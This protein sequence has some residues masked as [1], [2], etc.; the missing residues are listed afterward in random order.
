VDGLTLVLALAVAFVVGVAAGLLLAH[1]G[2]MASRLDPRLESLSAS[3]DRRLA[4]LD[5]R[6]GHSLETVQT[7][8]LEAVAVAADVRERIA[9]VSGVAQQVLEHAREL[10]R[11]EDLLRPP[12]A[13]GAF[14]EML[15]EQVLNQGLP[16]GT[17]RTQHSFR[18]GARV[19]A[20]LV[21]GERLVPVDAKFPLDAFTRMSALDEG[22]SDRQKHRRA[23]VR[24]ARG[25][26]DAI[27]DKYVRPDEGTYEF[28]LCYVPSE[29]VYYEFLRT[30]PD[31]ESVVRYAMQRQVFPVSPTTLYA[32]L[33]SI[34]LGLRGLRVEA[35]A[36][37]ILEG[38]DALRTETERL[39]GDL[40]VVGRHLGNA[41]AKW[42]EA[43]R[44]LDRF[45]HRLG[46]LAD[47]DVLDADPPGQPV[48][49]ASSGMPE[50]VGGLP[51]AAGRVDG[52]VRG[53]S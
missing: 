34:G 36:R 45:D 30:D 42:D 48:P 2:G 53:S 50:D 6:L 32:Y 35:N 8:Q 16:S 46:T 23:F 7:G 37:R 17:W 1:R 24:A 12:Q 47:P 20:V 33:L 31:G 18:S 19:D 39:R 43:A 9:Q 40:D 29:A 41:H 10:A 5:Q 44:R 4:A 13:R 15:L 51:G 38:L 25:H 26:V 3:L 28:A 22:E 14:G 49:T 27:A 52:A 21:L 11:V